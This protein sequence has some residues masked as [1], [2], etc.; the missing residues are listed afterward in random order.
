MKRNKNKTPDL[1]TIER[2][3]GS[4]EAYNKEQRDMALIDLEHDTYQGNY[5][6]PVLHW[7][8]SGRKGKKSDQAQKSG[9]S[10][11]LFDRPIAR[12]DSETFPIY[13]LE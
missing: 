4:L 8:F 9:R 3:W 11:R 12:T 7:D 1:E 10:F 6:G 2:Y 13:I 5:D